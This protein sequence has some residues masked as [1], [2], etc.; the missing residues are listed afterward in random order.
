MDGGFDI[1]FVI[2]ALRR[3]W[4]WMLPIFIVIGGAALAIAVL[5]PPVFKSQAKIIVESQQ[6]PADLVRS[7]VRTIADERLRLIEQRITTRDTLLGIIEKFGLYP[8]HRNSLTPT[9]LVERMRRQIS[10]SRFDLRTSRRAGGGGLAIGFTVGFEDRLPQIAS[11]VANE[12]VTLILS[13]DVKLRTSRASETTRFIERETDQ[14]R[15]ELAKL[16]AE[17]SAFKLKNDAS[18]PSRLGFQ[19][20]RLESAR[21]KV[22]N[23]DREIQSSREQYRLLE[24]ELSVRK[25]NVGKTDPVSKQQLV[26]RQLE[27]L[28]S[29]YARRKALYKETHPDL[30][31]L[32]EQIESLEESLIEA[33][34]VPAEVD[35]KKSDDGK[36]AKA[37]GDDRTIATL[38]VRLVNEKMVAL[39]ERLALAQKQREAATRQV[40]EVSDIIS[41]VPETQLVLGDYERRRDIVRSGLEEL[42]AKLNQAKLGER[43]EK[44]QQAERF[45]VIEQPIT[46][47]KPIKPNR[48]LILAIGLIMAL[49]LSGG[50]SI[51]PE[52]FNRTIRTSTDIVRAIGQP[53][54]ATIP[55]FATSAEISRRRLWFILGFVVVMS[56]AGGAMAY[57]HLYYMPLDDILYKS[58][59]RLGIF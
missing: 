46:P 19:M 59:R 10:I 3:R 9:E 47:S 28:R 7:T 1:H 16:E 17:I 31:A 55:R 8:E 56:A 39:K 2:A 4:Y 26:E 42:I 37:E 38:P 22:N 41:K 51:L 58:V 34:V 48:Q 36:T 24:L 40:A 5:W 50:L 43:L 45:E 30:K 14:R 12:L 13:A 11:R 6:I 20:G 18:L 52:I 53:A 25:A 44:D 57:L 27:A 49:G 33:V 35:K 54:I 23:L 15:K 29:E 32:K 21:N